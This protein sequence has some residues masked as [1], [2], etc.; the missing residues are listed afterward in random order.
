MIEI[1]TADELARMRKVGRIVAQALEMLGGL[2]KPG[3][4]T[5]ELDRAAE[6]FFLRQGAIPAF[7]GYQGFP[8]SICASVN[9][10]VVHGIPG[11]LVLVEGDI[12]GIDIGAVKDGFYGDSAMTFPVGQ[13][14]PAATQLMQVTRDALYQGIK[15]AIVGNR[16][17]DISHCIQTNVE[18]AGYSVVRDFVGHGIGRAMHEAPQIPNYGPP[19]KGPH[20]KAGMTLAIEPMV[21]AGGPDVEVLSDD[22][23]VVTCDGKLSAHFE[24]T[25]AITNN[26]PEILTVC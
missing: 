23:T 6:E 14:S 4:R 18:K 15:Q 24:H 5:Q 22:W 17:S 9:E 19:G 11:D 26:G 21:N 1:K 16:L 8:A 2:V 3:V 20:L 25:V 10:V 7:K 12:I 13:V